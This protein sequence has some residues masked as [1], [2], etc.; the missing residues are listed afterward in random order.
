MPEDHPSR[1]SE[2]LIEDSFLQANEEMPSVDIFWGGAGIDKSKVHPF[3]SS[4][5]GE[6]EMDNNFDMASTESQQFLLDLCTD[7]A[8]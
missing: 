3:N 2:L 8:T 4:Y 1:E 5:T 6:I 7:L